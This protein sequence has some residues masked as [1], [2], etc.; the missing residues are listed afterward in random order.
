MTSRRD[1]AIGVACLAAASAGY[2]LVPRR[3]VL[4]LP[5]EK[6]LDQIVPRAFGSWVSQDVSDLV[7]PKIEGSLMSKL[8]GETVGRVYS[9][10]D[11]GPEVMMLLAYGDTQTDDLQLHRPEICYPAFGFAISR[12]EPTD[13]EVGAGVSIPSRRLVADAPDRRET[14]VYW[15][16]LGEYLPRDRSEQQFDRLR[17]ALRGEIADGLLARFSVIGPDSTASLATIGT[18]APALLRAITPDR[19]AVFMG[20]QRALALVAAGV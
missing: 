16:R 3:R 20:S 13:L 17:T 19:R 4:L 14:I 7:A 8:Y 11:G 2:A 12:S 6:K 1:F 10:V 9:H 18:L 5:R 15:S